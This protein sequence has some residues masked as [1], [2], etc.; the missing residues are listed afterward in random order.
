MPFIGLITYLT[1]IGGLKFVFPTKNKTNTTNEKIG[2]DSLTF[3]HNL[4]LAIEATILFLGLVY[5]YIKVLRTEGIFCLYCDEKKSLSSDR[6]NGL[7]FW[8]RI[9]YWSKYHE[10]FDTVILCIRQKPLT[11]LHI[12]HHSVMP[13]VCWNALNPIMVP[14]CALATILNCFVHIF[15][16]AYFSMSAIGISLPFRKYIT[17]MQIIQFFII[18]TYSLP[19]LYLKYYLG[20]D[21][22]GLLSG[23]LWIVVPVFIILLF[24]SNFYMK[25]YKSKNS[26][27]DA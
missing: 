21:C 4:I 25:Q 10:L 18:L 12:F 22:S 1:V 20:I 23:W 9:Y 11:T 2:N 24:F 16:Y 5:Y 14:P 17:S 7:Y 6:W 27:K 3:I 8:N 19:W 15:M 13:F 26:M